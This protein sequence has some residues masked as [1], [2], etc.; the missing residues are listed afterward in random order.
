MAN[1]IKI[2]KSVLTD[3]AG[4]IG[5]NRTANPF[6]GG[7][8]GAGTSTF[9]SVFDRV[10]QAIEDGD[11]S[12]NVGGDLVLTEEVTSPSITEGT[13]TRKAVSASVTTTAATTAVI[14]VNVPVGAKLIGAQFIVTTAIAY[15]GD[16]TAFQATWTASTQAI[17]GATT[18][19]KNDKGK[20][21]YNENANSAIVSGSV[22]TI[23][24]TANNTGAFAAG[25]VVLAVAW[26]DEL[27]DLP[28][29]A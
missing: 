20:A 26:Y 6:V 10:T 1:D 2:H 25:G 11:I 21:L 18:G 5:A 27:S 15:T 19:A 28:D 29:V 8:D 16:S 9:V 23:T 4:Y 24:L 14:P 17:G 12:V 22:E 13:F 7:G 3:E